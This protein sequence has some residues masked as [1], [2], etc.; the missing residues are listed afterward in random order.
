VKSKIQNPT[1]PP[2]RK[3]KIVLVL[4]VG[5]IIRGDDGFGVRV[6]EE[7]QKRKLPANVK[8]V[9]AEL[10]GLAHTEEIQQAGRVIIIDAIDARKPPG[11][12]VIFTPEQVR[13][14]DTDASPH[15]VGMLGILKLLETLGH[16]PPVTIVGCRRGNAL[17]GEILSSEV[18]AAV[19]KAV[20]LIGNLLTRSVT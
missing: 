14:L 9:T 11:A 20:D 3:S 8:V 4:G 10:R 6:A 7:L 17:E 13:S 18:A 5:S 15:G 16:C 19:P 2:W 12:L 1:C